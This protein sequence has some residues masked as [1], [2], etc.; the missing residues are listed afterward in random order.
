MNPMLHEELA[1][2][3]PELKL[4]CRKYEVATL[5]I[6]GSAASPNWDPSVSNLDFFVVFEPDG[7]GGLVDRYPGLADDLEALFNR[8]VD[9]V[10]PG[11][12]RNP[13]F[14]DAIA[15]TRARVYGKND[16][17]KLLYD[18]ASSKAIREFCASA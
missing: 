2:K 15:A 18:I 13:F 4:L 8:K 1:E 7:G 16:A 5:D 14:R 9:L 11:A 6:F 3:R 12:I 10:T 17:R